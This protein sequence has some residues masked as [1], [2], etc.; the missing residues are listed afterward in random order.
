MKFYIGPIDINCIITIKNI[1]AFI[2]KLMTYLKKKKLSVVQQSA[3]R[4][5]CICSQ[6]NLNFDVELFKMEGVT[7]N[8][9]RFRKF[10]GEYSEYRKLC[11]QIMGGSK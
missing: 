2:E 4:I 3:Y 7:S 11:N 9:I 8:Y 1:S 6:S 5:K 10:Q